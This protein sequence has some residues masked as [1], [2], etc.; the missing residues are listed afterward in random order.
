[1][2]HNPFGV[3]KLD[4]PDTVTVWTGS[5]RIVEG[6]QAGFQFC[7]RPAAFRT[8]KPVRENL[9]FIGF[10]IEDGCFAICDTQGGFKTFCQALPDIGVDP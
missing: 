4:V 5:H 3:E 8:G 9:F 7:Q 2:L 10:H 6:E 1:M